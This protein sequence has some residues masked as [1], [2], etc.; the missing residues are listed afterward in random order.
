MN[1]RLLLVAVAG[2]LLLAFVAVFALPAH[3]QDG[4]DQNPPANVDEPPSAPTRL[5]VVDRRSDSLLLSWTA[6]DNA[7]KP[8]ITGTSSSTACT[9]AAA[10]APGSPSS[11]PGRGRPEPSPTWP[12]TRST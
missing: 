8:A 11:I 10:T 6:P 1:F 9:A 4:T 3:A 12:R 5:R 2:A 7:G